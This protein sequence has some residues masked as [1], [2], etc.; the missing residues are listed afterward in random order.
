MPLTH[1]AIQNAKPSEKPYKLS[2]GGGLFLLIQP[3]G[4]KLWRL[5]YRHHGTER[6][7]SFGAYP[8]ISLSDARSRRDEAKK[9]MSEG[10]D[11]AVQRKLEKIAAET[12]SRNTFGLVAEEYVSNLEAT[13][14]APS[15]INKNRWLLEDLAKPLSNRP[16]GEITPAEI[17]DLLNRIERSGRRETAKRLRATIG[18]VF[19]LAVATLRAPGDPIRDG[20]ARFRYPQ[21]SSP[22][23]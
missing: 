21:E 7:L 14:A 22:T 3:N 1:F 5:K 23:S 15:T 4:S 13:G 2:D 17:L 6:L 11:P 16:V 9:L 12:A 8:A 10:V 18:A 20:S 19:R